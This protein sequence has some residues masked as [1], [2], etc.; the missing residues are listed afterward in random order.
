MGR[1][2]RAF[3]VVA[4]MCTHPA[5]GR[6][7]GECTLEAKL[8]GERPATTSDSPNFIAFFIGDE[9]SDDSE[10]ADQ[11]EAFAE[12]EGPSFGVAEDDGTGAAQVAAEDYDDRSLEVSAAEWL[13]LDFLLAK[14]K[15]E[16]SEGGLNCSGVLRP[17]CQ[18]RCLGPPSLLG[19]L[20]CSGV[21]RPS[22][23][24][25][26]LGPPSLPDNERWEDFKGDTSDEEDG[27]L[28]PAGLPI[29]CSTQV[30]EGFTFPRDGDATVAETAFVFDFCSTFNGGCSPCPGMCGDLRWET[31]QTMQAL[32]I[33]QEFGAL[34]EQTYLR[35]ST[36]PSGSSGL[37]LDEGRTLTKAYW[38]LARSLKHAGVGLC[39]C[40]W[41]S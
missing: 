9:D 32:C 5:P 24:A 39:A 23:Q 25:R 4:Q 16:R 35:S 31:K 15:E 29:F 1:G 36:K 8:D 21:L 40:A 14:W 11:P 7:Q 20:D 27:P 6:E 38:R 17:S 2:R 37:L 33:E 19:G 28:E 10:D 3:Q 34:L 30:Y 12:N 22:C 18:A 13:E 26:C 41:R